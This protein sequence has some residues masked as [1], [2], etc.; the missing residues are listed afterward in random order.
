MA[1][2]RFPAAIPTTY[3]G[4]IASHMMAVLL[5]TSVTSVPGTAKSVADLTSMELS[6]GGNYTAT[7]GV[8]SSSVAVQ[9][10]DWVF[11]TDDSTG[12]AELGPP[13][14]VTLGTQFLTLSFRWVAFCTDTKIVSLVDYGTTQTL[15]GQ[16]F[17]M[18]VPVSA[19]ISGSYPVVRWHRA[20]GI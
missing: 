11:A 5:G 13:A 16:P 4:G 6:T 2:T 12:Y 17:V 18:S 10:P 20:S 1:T 7:G 14:A 9:L 19:T 3:T 15:A 8:W